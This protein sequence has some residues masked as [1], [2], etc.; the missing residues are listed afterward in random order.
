MNLQQTIIRKHS[1]KQHQG[2]THTHKHMYVD[3][4]MMHNLNKRTI[5]YN[6]SVGHEN[7]EIQKYNSHTIRTRKV[8]KNKK[9][10]RILQENYRN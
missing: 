5:F 9:K 1:Q 7:Q 8:N 3:C 10:S 4:M 6:T 2:C